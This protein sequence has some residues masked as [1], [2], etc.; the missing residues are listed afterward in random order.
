M[1]TT[2]TARKL[3]LALLLA[4]TASG[5]SIERYA[6]GKVADALAGTGGTFASDEDVD[7]I[8]E[9]SP[10]G[11]KLMENV[12][13]S[14]PDHQELL[15]ALARGFVQYAYA[16][17]A[18]DGD[19]AESE[20]LARAEALRERA[21]KLYLRGREY[22]LRA[23]EVCQPGFRAELQR[24]PRAAAAMLRAPEM[25]ALYWTSAGWGAA[26]ALSKD[27]PDVVADQ[28]VL[29]ALLD[30]ALLLD[31]GYGAGAL[32][33]ILISYEPSRIGGDR[34]ARD[35][36]RKQFE[37]AV[38]L[39]R[40]RSVGPYVAL[41]ESVAIAEQDRA[42]FLRLLG[43]ALAI[44]VDAAPERRVE[45]LVQQRRARW[46]LSRVDELFLE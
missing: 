20:S 4:C 36:A 40:G 14:Q 7:L 35:R 18:L 24:D 27:R 33:T 8:R 2:R 41:A 16:F 22:G 25:E 32:R 44:E 31:E 6:T 17:V 12:L 23:L 13:Q 38:E 34:G 26:I 10:F 43:A 15:T 46:L 19:I 5:C 9:A 28:P 30:R 37:R 45:N 42:E 3:A 11:L 29:E 39:S 21:R 1:H